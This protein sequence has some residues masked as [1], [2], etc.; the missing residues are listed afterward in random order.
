MI[1][2]AGPNGAGK[3]TFGD[4]FLRRQTKP[5]TYIN[6][7]EI[8]KDI[9]K[10]QSTKP[11]REFAAARI[12]LR[13]LACAVD[14]GENIMIETTLAVRTYAN[15]IPKWQLLGYRVG[16]SYLRLPS[17]EIAIERVRRR[18]ALGGHN[19]QV[20]VIRRRFDTGRLYLETLYKP[21]VDEWYVW[22]SIEGD[23]V[24]A[25]AWNLP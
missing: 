12:A 20:D 7:D 15:A 4:L 9:V 14:A 25:E 18:V 22:D 11:E 3:S 8:E 1:I 17:A 2:V 5:F 24:P 6:A 16:L 23:F 13:R 21:A 19:I 10:L